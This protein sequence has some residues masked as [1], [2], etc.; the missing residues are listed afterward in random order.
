MQ[1]LCHGKICQGCFP[2]NTSRSKGV[3]DLVHSNVCGPMSSESFKGYSYYVNF[4][5]DYSRKT[6]IYFLNAKDEVFRKFQEFM[7]LVENKM[8][9]KTKVLRSDNGGDYT[10]NSFIDFYVAM[11][12]KKDLIVPYNP[13]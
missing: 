4:V 7:A 6:W 10:L 5:D 8:G 2:P 1:G 13:Q 3:L 12:I 9:K 11:G